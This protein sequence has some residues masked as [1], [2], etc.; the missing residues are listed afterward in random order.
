V[1]DDRFGALVADLTALDDQGLHVGVQRTVEPVAGEALRLQLE[2]LGADHPGI[3]AEI[4][5]ALA[6]RHVSIEELSTDVRD[7]PMAGGTLF[8]ARAVLVAPPDTSTDVLRAMLEGLAD[9]LMVEI[10]LSDE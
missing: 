5:A 1:A 8:E 2:L 9:E 3:V 4:S 6:D 7:A 10:T